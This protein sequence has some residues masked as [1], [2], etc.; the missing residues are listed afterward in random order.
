MINLK[1]ELNTFLISRVTT[2]EL[3]CS[4]FITLSTKQLKLVIHLGFNAH[5]NARCDRCTWMIHWESGCGW[6]EQIAEYLQR[7]Y[8]Q[9]S[10]PKCPKP[11]C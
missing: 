10:T 3:V 11:V 9:P 2:S 5:R 6:T 8:R 4:Y 1:P 7:T